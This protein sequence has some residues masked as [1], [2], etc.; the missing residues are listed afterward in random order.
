MSRQDWTVMRED[1]AVVVER[2]LEILI[3]QGDRGLA[4]HYPFKAPAVSPAMNCR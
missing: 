1:V 4:Q 3:F 2:E